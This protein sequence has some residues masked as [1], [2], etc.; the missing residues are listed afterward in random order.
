MH[1]NMNLRSL[2]PGKIK[3]DMEKSLVTQ[4]KDLKQA[5]SRDNKLLYCSQTSHNIK[6]DPTA[7]L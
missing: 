3:K 4:P 2:H 5:A 7:N 1:F 6:T